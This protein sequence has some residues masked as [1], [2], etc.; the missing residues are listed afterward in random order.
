ML[1]NG[2]RLRVPTHK[3][4]LSRQPFRNPL[5]LF[6]LLQYESFSNALRVRKYLLRVLYLIRLDP[7][8]YFHPGFIQQIL[9]ILRALA[10]D[11]E[12]DAMLYALQL[13]IELLRA[14]SSPRRIASQSAAG[15]SKGGMVKKRA[16]FVRSSGA[17]P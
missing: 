9:G 7:L 15:V 5:K 2:A 17:G 11:E 10:F 6:Q 14:E 16:R 13:G 12:P 8:N 3:G 1:G 4:F